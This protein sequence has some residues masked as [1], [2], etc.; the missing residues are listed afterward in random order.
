LGPDGTGQVNFALAFCEYFVIVAGLGIPLYGIRET[1]KARDNIND[2]SKIFFEIFSIR[3]FTTITLL[4]PYFIVVIHIKKFSEDLTLYYWGAVYIVANMGSIDWFFTGLEDFKYITSRSL[5]V[6]F[7]SVILMFFIVKHKGDVL[8]Y[9]L[10][11]VFILVT[12]SVID[13]RYALKYLTF[14]IDWAGLHFKKHLKPL[15]YIF[16]SLLAIKVYTL[17]DT[18]ILG[19]LSS[20]QSVGYYNSAIKLVRISLTVITS[21]GTVL[22]ARLSNAVSKNDFEEMNKLLKNSFSFV[23]TLGIPMMALIFALAPELVGLF[24]GYKFNP[25]VL[26]LRILCPQIL[27]IGMANVFSVQILTP[28]GKDRLVMTAAIAGAFVNVA[29]NFLLVPLIGHNGSAI[30]NLVTELLV[31]IICFF[32]AAKFIEI[33]LQYKELLLNFTGTLPYLFLPFILR[34]YLHN[35]FLISA[36]TLFTA[37]ISFLLFNLYVI[38][39]RIV[40]DILTRLRNKWKVYFQ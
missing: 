26:T 28:L 16:S 27:I 18:V 29:L 39:S 11:T 21:L 15:F 37:A 19:F 10:I 2:R 5:A 25:A 6:K 4:V 7:I 35:Y 24:S 33:N 30:S 14:K 3:L 32:F 20:N 31:T 17:A 13:L 1:A 38:K 34:L 22:I 36:F 12:N 23:Y 9:F 8:N 40:L